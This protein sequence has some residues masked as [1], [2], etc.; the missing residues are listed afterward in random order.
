MSSFFV[1][2]QLPGPIVPV[3]LLLAR[4]V[5]PARAEIRAAAV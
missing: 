1:I 3:C 2:Y 4:S 5:A